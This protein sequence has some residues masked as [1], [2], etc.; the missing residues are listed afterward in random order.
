[1]ADFIGKFVLTHLR[2][3]FPFNYVLTVVVEQDR[4]QTYLS[5]KAKLQHKFDEACFQHSRVALVG[6]R[7]DQTA[8]DGGSRS[9]MIKLSTM[10][11]M[12]KL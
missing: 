3:I 6:D 4:A 8:P 5:V 2:L 10:D 12:C 1:M 9:S 7:A 11:N